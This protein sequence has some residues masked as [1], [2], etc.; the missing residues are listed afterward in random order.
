MTGRRQLQSSNV[1][2]C[3]VPRSRTSLGDQSFTVAGLQLWNN[4]PLNLRDSE[5]TLL[6][7]PPATEDAP[8]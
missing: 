7:V 6:G 4:L 8:V 2:M 1:A 5:L 3:E